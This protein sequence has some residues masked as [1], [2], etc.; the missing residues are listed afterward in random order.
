MSTILDALRKLQVD[1]EA[2]KPRSKDLRTEVSVP[3][4]ARTPR[5][6]SPALGNPW[7]LGLGVAAILSLSV[8]GYGRLGG[9]GEADELLEADASLLDD[10]QLLDATLDPSN[11]DPNGM[12]LALPEVSV[13][14]TETPPQQQPAVDYSAYEKA[15][16]ARGGAAD[17]AQ[18]GPTTYSDQLPPGVS[19]GGAY[20]GVNT[21]QRVAAAELP[22]PAAAYRPPQPFDP[23]RD[24]PRREPSRV[25]EVE[26]PV[27][28]DPVPEEPSLAVAKPPAR[29]ARPKES[30][31]VA[32]T[33]TAEPAREEA[34]VSPSP[35][36]DIRVDSV[37]WHPD[38]ARRQAVIT[39]D[40]TRAADV[41]EGDVIGGVTVV[42][43][44]PGAVEMKAGE[45]RKRVGIAP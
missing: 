40:D 37:V 26:S 18:G 35:F 21:Q 33:A 43:I 24:E 12:T 36:P 28:E 41:R 1:R 4:P 16:I 29:R 20:A 27:F 30:A 3:A 22:P 15:W 5:K 39:L 23:R 13:D 10:P 19:S 2:T 32:E 11:L 31:P 25:R 6:A 7:V 8:Y 42:R 44:E 17:P 14:S 38:P 45:E 34:F 9:S